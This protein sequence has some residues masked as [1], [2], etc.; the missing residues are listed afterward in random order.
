MKIR[1]AHKRRAEWTLFQIT[2]VAANVAVLVGAGVVLYVQTWGTVC[3]HPAAEAKAKTDIKGWTTAVSA[4]KLNHPNVGYPATLE[5]LTQKD[6][7]GFGPYIANAEILVDPWGQ[8]YKY[9]I[10]GKRNGG[11]HPD[12][13]TV[14]PADEGGGIIGNWSPRIQR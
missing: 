12:I 1:G 5:Q 14:R 3:R 11:R 13:F 6:E 4:Y 9:E 10:D 2:M 8:P 7:Q